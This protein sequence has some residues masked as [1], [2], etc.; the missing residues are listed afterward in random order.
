MTLP[1]VR[2]DTSMPD[3]PKIVEL[4]AARGDVGRAAAFVWVCSM[5]YAGKH[6]TDGFISRAVLARLNGLPKHAK[7]LVEF[8]LWDD[9]PPKGWLV[10]DYADYNPTVATLEQLAD[11]ARAGG[12]ARMN[13]MS[14][15]ERSELARKAA[16]ARW[17]DAE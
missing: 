10:H 17:A 8:R 3:N 14:P 5:A 12:R 7:L 11:S 15:E 16:R 13:G 4:C 6:G 2:L 1:W 9:L